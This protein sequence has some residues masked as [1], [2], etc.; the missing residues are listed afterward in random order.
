MKIQFNM[1]VLPLI[2]TFTAAGATCVFA[3]A[4]PDKLALGDV[5]SMALSGNP[6]IKQAEAAVEKSQSRLLQYKADYFPSLQLDMEYSS[7]SPNSSVS[8]PGFGNFS[9]YPDNSYDYHIALS[10]QLFTFGRNSANVSAGQWGVKA[11]ESNLALVREQ[12]EFQ[13]VQLFYGI[14]LMERQISSQDEDIRTLHEYLEMTESKAK[15]G[16]ATD[17]DALTIEVKLAE[18]E[19]VRATES[20]ELD[21]ERIDLARLIGLENAGLPE[22]YGELI[23]GESIPTEGEI[24]PFGLEHNPELKITAAQAR[25]SQEQS[26]AA[27][28][29]YFPSVTAGIQYGEKN[30]Y[31]PGMDQMTWNSMGFIQI[32]IPLFNISS[33]GARREAQAD[34][35]T[36]TEIHRD[37]QE[38]VVSDIKRAI[39][40]L[41]SNK[42]KI[43]SAKL[44]VSLAGKAEEQAKIR[45]EGGMIT[46]LDLLNAE[47][48]LSRAK[49]LYF[50]SVYDFIISRASLK[51]A[52][53]L[54]QLQNGPVRE[55]R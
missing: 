32:A 18:A 44:N 3:D 35:K 43:D 30:G 47:A 46:E 22:I 6:V 25:Q 55:E 4:M 8:V 36:A 24:M 29:Q 34:Y 41:N 10:Q 13:A 27:E 21:K 7:L 2:L 40:D 48:D 45:Y 26:R 54:A 23:P 38:K 15:I 1:C 51:K 19:S 20:G 42:A 12:V 39:S 50:Q 49:S 5:V 9:L 11:S 53:G 52:A 37:T 17:F 31:F 16:V 28:L 14:L 33:I